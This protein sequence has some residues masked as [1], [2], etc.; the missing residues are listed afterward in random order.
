MLDRVF[1]DA[2]GLVSCFLKGSLIV[3]Q[4]RSCLCFVIVSGTCMTSHPYLIS[5]VYLSCDRRLY[6][7]V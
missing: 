7:S 5:E 6:N 1:F 4:G 3:V 2:W